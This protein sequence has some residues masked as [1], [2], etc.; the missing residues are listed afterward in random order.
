[1]AAA[2]VGCLAPEEEAGTEPEALEA[3]KLAD[4]ARQRRQRGR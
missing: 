3:V 2:G 1:M 4:R